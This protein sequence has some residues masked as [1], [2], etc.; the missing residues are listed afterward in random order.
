MVA[1][2]INAQQ[3]LA[4]GEREALRADVIKGLSSPQKSIPSRWLYDAKGS[5][6]FEE[7][8]E[9][10]EYYPTRTERAILEACSGDIARRTPAGCVL[11]EFGSGSSIKTEVLLRALDKASAYVALD[12]S[13]P[14]LRDAARRI[15][16][17]FPS[18]VVEPI[19][20]DFCDPVRLP[21]HLEAAP[22]L[23]FFPGSTIGN[24]QPTDAVCLL[25]RFGQTLGRGG[26]LIIGV[27]LQKDVARLE[28]AYD[29]RKGVTAAFN[30]NLL[31]R[32]N[33]ELD[34]DFNLKAFRH[35][36]LYNGVDNR[37]EMHLVSERDQDVRVAGRTF[38][39]KT[40]ET[41]HTENSYKYTVDGFHARAA[42]AGWLAV[43]T[44]TDD[45]HLFSVHELQFG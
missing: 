33:R 39:F 15:S 19:V 9:L 17:R 44:W 32:L 6:L 35:K 10:D 34:G 28:A 12:I 37:I 22:R 25:E 4:T 8:T 29:D 16:N 18:L 26:R 41:I 11:I 21:A 5:D 23:G 14:A 27:D 40:E 1:L 3:P 20:A 31:R 38:S 45:A 43:E 30:L 13:E 2:G 7:I 36:A 42:Q 24:L